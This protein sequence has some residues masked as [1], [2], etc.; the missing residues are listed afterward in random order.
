MWKCTARIAFLNFVVP[1]AMT[2]KELYSILF[3]FN[4]HCQPGA[5]L[6]GWHGVATATLK[7]GLA[8]PAARP[9]GSFVL[10]EKLW[11]IGHL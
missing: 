1:D 6:S 9:V 5:D 10:K 7:K 3:V 4:C 2:I 11:L 8:T